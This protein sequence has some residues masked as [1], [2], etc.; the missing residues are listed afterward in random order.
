MAPLS[1]S[2]LGPFEV[3][4]DGRPVTGFKSKKVRGL[5]AYLAVESSRPHPR[6]VLA[7]LLW[8]D[9]PDSEALSNLRYALS[10]LR[11]VI[12]DR[13]AEPCYL[14]ITRD[15]LQFNAASDYALDISAFTDRMA[16][17]G[18]TARDVWDLA[19]VEEA[20]ALYRGAFLEGFSIRDSVAFEEWS[21]LKR[22]QVAYQLLAGVQY[23]VKSYEAFGQHDQALTWARRLV[24]LEPWDEAAHRRMM[25]LLVLNGRRSAALV[26]YESCRQILEDELG[27]EP[28]LETTRLYEEIRKGE[29]AET[30][31]PGIRPIEGTAAIPCFLKGEAPQVEMPVFVARNKELT[32]L[33]GYLERA[34]AGH[35]RVAFVTGEAGSGKTALIQEFGRRA[36]LEHADLVVASG[37][38]NAY[39]GIGDPYLPFREILELLTGDVEAK[40]VAGAISSEHAQRLWRMFPVTAEALVEVGRDLINTFVAHAALLERATACESGRSEWL[41]KLALLEGRMPAGG[42]G[43]ASSQQSDLFEQYSRVLQALAVE[44][45]LLLVVDD[46]QWADLGSISQLFHLGKHLTGSRILIIGA[47]RPEEVSVGRP[48]ERH[49]LDSVVNEIQRDFGDVTVNLRKAE[50]REFVEALLESEPNRLGNA[51]RDKLFR[52]TQGQPLFSIELL[53]GMQERGD[54][55]QDSR[56]RWVEG[57]A[58]DWE[59]MPARVEAVIGE[60]LSRLPRTLQSTLRVASVEGEVFTAEV[61][62]RI[63]KTDDRELVERL[64]DELDR[65]HR[66][67]RA[68]AIERVGSHRVSR[69]RFRNYLFQKYMYDHLDE[70]ER[71]YLHEDV[72]KV[73]E[74]Y[75]GEG[76]E[77]MAVQLAWHFQEAGIVEKAIPYLAQAGVKSVQLA[78][79]QEGITH[80]KR[81]LELLMTLPDSPDRASLELDLQLPLILADKGLKGVRSSETVAAFTRAQELCQQ[82]G[83]SSQLSRVLEVMAEY[84]FVGAE[85]RKAREL[86]E[87]NLKVAEGTGNP[88]QIAMCQWTLGYISFSM[89][90]FTSAHDQFEQVLRFYEPQA[91]HQAFI[92]QSGKDAGL[93][94]MAHDA[95]CLWVL[96]Y[97][98]QAL[99][100]SQEALA[101]AFELNHPFTLAEGLCFAW[102]YFNAM[103]RDAAALKEGA[104][105]LIR[106]ADEQVPGWMGNGE[107]LDGEALVRMGQVEEGIAQ[108]LKGLGKMA[109]IGLRLYTT[110]TRS[111]LA[112][113]Q[114]KAGRPEEGLATLEKTLAQVEE[115]GERYWEAEI[116]RLRAELLLILGDG[117]EA[118]VSLEKAIEIARRQSGK[119]LELRA[120]IDLARLW[121]KQG[122]VEEA[123]QV[124]EPVT[125]WFSE[126]FDT[127]DLLEAKELLAEISAAEVF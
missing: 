10:N 116:H 31:T 59:T 69:Y 45:P 108:I 53:R 119:L 118:E 106:L 94:A 55:V 5:L 38:C 32:Q 93:G 101:L 115:T 86:A 52:Q 82:T 37:N 98:D 7:G 44:R 58:L 43:T 97:P 29:P 120:T 107:C 21:S 4:L 22:Q 6:E 72:G 81:G 56:G 89:G 36:Q 49:P 104:E 110:R 109:S 24:E 64:S 1:L 15:T 96:G 14:L 73:L 83:R 17:A 74:A 40:W 90:E 125:S 61:L 95:C 26:Q 80:L 114:A 78:A 103:R 122:R 16:A 70:V 18:G 47:Y 63:Q 46:L 28:A 19:G 71:A 57:P 127:P 8:P 66:L 3:K 123:W 105:A 34:M 23:M 100:R 124:L 117:S 30:E 121:A 76:Q 102:C 20:M 60:R 65:R 75:Y 113:G 126:G 85:Y 25:R 91:H 42:L 50:H 35:G 12:G 87:E 41:A 9:W 62:A 79:Y 48:G 68:Q 2:C 111:A 84:H 27:V 13:T 51:F 33:G 112:L 11:R 99:K 92:L 39:T 88:L 54:L 77:G 67:I